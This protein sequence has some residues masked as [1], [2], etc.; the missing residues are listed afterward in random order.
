MAGGIQW[1]RFDIVELIYELLD[2]NI[3]NAR[4]HRIRF[5]LNK[6][7]SDSEES[8]FVHADRHRISQVINQLIVNAIKYSKKG[9]HITIGLADAPD[10][11][12]VEISDEG[13]GICP[14][15]FPK[16]FERCF[17]PDKSGFGDQ[18][19][20]LGLY[21]VKKVID[22]HRETMKVRSNNGIGTTFT[23]TLSKHCRQPEAVS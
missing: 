2:T 19:V 12:S 7:V 22:A 5:R 1:N 20:R 11:V 14:S 3:L 21:G 8:L 6:A 10:Q 23:F 16:V 18:E 13:I 4:E 15:D 17:L 9:S